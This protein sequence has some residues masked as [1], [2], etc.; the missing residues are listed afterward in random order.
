MKKTNGIIFVLALAM[1]ACA[2][3]MLLRL[4]SQQKLAPPGLKIGAAPLFDPEGKQVASRSISL[5]ETVLDY[6]SKLLP[7]TAQEFMALPKDTTFGKRIYQSTDG[8]QT[9]VSVVMMGTDRTSIHKPE[10]CLVSQGWAID[11]ANEVS[12]SITQP[13]PYNLPVMRLTTSLPSKDENGR[14]LT[15]RGLYLYWF[16]ADNQ[17]TAKHT[18]RVW[19]TVKNLLKNG[20]LQRW[21][22]VTYFAQCWPGQEEATFERMK[23][24]IAASVPEFQ[25]TT[26]TME[27]R[28][29]SS[30]SF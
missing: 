28:I 22:Y 8:F 24:F 20:T 26:G 14:T 10:F 11:Q 2:A 17:L 19:G 9:M 21:S 25:L 12:L 16:V 6:H 27:A 3:G 18:E 30:A 7:V 15:R 13:V 5:P 29:V 1:I 23:K 4:K